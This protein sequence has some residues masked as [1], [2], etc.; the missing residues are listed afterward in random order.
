[1]PGEVEVRNVSLR[2]FRPGGHIKLAVGIGA[3][4]VKKG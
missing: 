4:Y 3:C 2:F 1:M